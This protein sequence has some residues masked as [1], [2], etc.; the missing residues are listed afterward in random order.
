MLFWNFYCFIKVSTWNFG[1]VI[2]RNFFISDQISELN[3]LNNY[4]KIHIW[5]HSSNFRNNVQ[6]K[7]EHYSLVYKCD[8]LTIL[9]NIFTIRNKT[10]ICELIYSP[11]YIKHVELEDI[12][13]DQP[14]NNRDII[15]QVDRSYW[16]NCVR[17][18]QEH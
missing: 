18:C 17:Y 11:R 12:N 16:S 10:K 9:E 2:L 14:A 15:F 13:Q 7:Y 5:Q 3:R 8:Y 6:K 4:S 1:I